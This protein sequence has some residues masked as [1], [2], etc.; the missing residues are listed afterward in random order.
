[1]K[2]IS[3][4][5]FSKKN[6]NDFVTLHYVTWNRRFLY[7]ANNE[8]THCQ[9]DGRVI[10][11]E[12]INVSSSA[13]QIF[14]RCIHLGWNRFAELGHLP[15]FLLSA[16]NCIKP[17][18]QLN[19]SAVSYQIYFHVNKLSPS[20]PAGSFERSIDV[21]QF[22]TFALPS[23]GENLCIA[24]FDLNIEWKKNKSTLS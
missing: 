18:S 16:I 4:L 10:Q 7:R 9:M 14:T 12:S 1:M 24:R 11:I 5:H 21:A 23:I 22:S 13:V 15:N 17:F 6:K 3:S 19:L 8:S 2:K 20:S